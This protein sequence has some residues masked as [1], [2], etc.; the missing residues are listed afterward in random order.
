MLA[1]HIQRPKPQ[2]LTIFL[3]S[4]T[5]VTEKSKHE[6]ALFYND[7]YE[8]VLPD[9]HTFPM[10]KY[11]LVREGLQEEL[12]GHSGI[13][14]EVSPLATNDEL[15]STHCPKY[16]HR[17]TSGKLT[18]RENRKIGFPWSTAG[19]HRS[20][21]SVGGTIAATRYVCTTNAAS[22]CHIAGGTH[23]AFYDYGEGY[24]VFSDIAVAANVALQ[25]LGVSKVLIIDLDVHQGNGNASLFQN[26]PR[27]FTFSVHCRQNLF[28]E[29]QFSDL[30]I[31]LEA[32]DG[33]APYLE[34]LET[35]LPLLIGTVQPDLIFY[36][37]GV[38]I[39]KDDRLG[40]LKLT[41]EGLRARNRL[42]F[43]AAKDAGAKVVTTMGGGYP[44]SLEPSFSSFVGI[45]EAHKDVYRDCIR[46]YS[47]S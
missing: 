38:D 40:K 20:L 39:Y 8:H 37:A 21:S 35:Q 13:F 36:Q 14:F 18:A 12:K 17:F 25:T 47:Y 23:H 10:E 6:V 4:I 32:G 45:I 24:C 22:A 9:T 31:E 16:V 44:R 2:V 7:V 19:V 41:R 43:H 34:V 29:R 15:A 28:S 5:S 42:V 46:T 27:V 11:R 33:D 3:R 30:D 1:T 26:E